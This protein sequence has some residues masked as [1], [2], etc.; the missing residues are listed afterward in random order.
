MSTVAQ[1]RF[2]FTSIIPIIFNNFK[3]NAQRELQKANKKA[4]RDVLMQKANKATDLK[5][6]EDIID[7]QFSKIL[8]EK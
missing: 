7:L 6:I 1:P 3:E 5:R 8:E 2:K 4:K